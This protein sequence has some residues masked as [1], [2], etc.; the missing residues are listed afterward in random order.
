MPKKRTKKQTYNAVFDAE[1]S[2][3]HYQWSEII[4]WIN[5]PNLLDMHYLEMHQQIR[6]DNSR[7]Y[8]CCHQLQLQVQH[9]SF[10]F[11]FLFFWISI[12]LSIVINT[13]NFSSSHFTAGPKR[14]QNGPR[15][16]KRAAHFSLGPKKGPV[17]FC[18]PRRRS[19]CG[20][21][22]CV[23][24]WTIM[25]TVFPLNSVVNFTA[26]MSPECADQVIYF[27]RPKT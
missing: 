10:S 12:Q 3:F 6:R 14:R 23:Q 19:R 2:N 18:G 5:H 9:P 22:I 11:S 16:P 4:T 25:L 20:P 26:V 24:P 8:Y 27:I 15:G 17:A 21:Q 13:C 7:L 1:A